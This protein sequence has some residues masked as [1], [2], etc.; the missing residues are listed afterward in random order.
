M[1][2][3]R[4]TPEEKTDIMRLFIGRRRAERISLRSYAGETGIPYYNLS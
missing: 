2:Q 4:Y 1:R 3:R